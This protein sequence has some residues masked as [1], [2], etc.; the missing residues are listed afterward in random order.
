MGGIADEQAEA[1]SQLQFWPVVVLSLPVE[2][3]KRHNLELGSGCMADDG[4]G[5][6]VLRVGTAAAPVDPSLG[7]AVCVG[8]LADAHDDGGKGIIAWPVAF[9]S[10]L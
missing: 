10:R 5:E 2:V 4:T 3:R 8:Q 9:R 6:E 7:F 1:I